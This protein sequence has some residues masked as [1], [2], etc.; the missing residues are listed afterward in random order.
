MVKVELSSD[1]MDYGAVVLTADASNE[2]A[3]AW[4]DIGVSLAVL[5]TF[6]T[7]VLGLVYGTVARGLRPLKDLNVAFVRVG[8]GDYGARVAENGAIELVHIAREFNQMVARISTM[9][10][11]NDRLNEQLTS[12]QEEERAD[13]ARELHDEIGPF[14]FAVSLDVSAMH[15]I[16]GEDVTLQ[17]APRLEAIRDAVAHMQKHLKS[18]LGRLRPTVLLDLRLPQAFDNLVDFW[19]GR[20]PNVVFNIETYQESFGGV[21]D[22]GIYRIIRESVNNAL[23]H[24]RPGRIDVN[25]QPVTDNMVTV[26]VVDDGGGIKSH[27]P[28]IGFGITGMQERVA[29]LGGVLTVKN[30][31]D[32]RGVI[33]MAR[34]PLQPPSNF[35]TEEVK[36]ASSA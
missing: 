29:S 1:T 16:A 23:N 31:M 13:L 19:K 36:E 20:H 21:L 24:G 35:L 30:R 33:V 28:V 3:E 6:L 18:I 8:R 2:L 12:V 4:S 15:Q 34:L 26:T 25:I 14:L 10:L 7:L 5:V 32:G 27:G 22:D 11:Q 9:K 17:L